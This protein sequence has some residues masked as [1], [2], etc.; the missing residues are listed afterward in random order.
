M[1]VRIT[2]TVVLLALLALTSVY[3]LDVA[4]AACAGVVWLVDH[5]WAG[6]PAFVVAFIVLPIVRAACKR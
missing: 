4:L 5:P 3:W 1:M 6:G 2:G